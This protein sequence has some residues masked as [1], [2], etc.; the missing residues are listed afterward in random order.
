M[1]TQNIK[2]EVLIITKE[3]GIEKILTEELR[4]VNFGIFE[5]KTYEEIKNEYPNKVE[6]MRNDWRNFK[7]DKGESINEMMLRTAKKMDEI[8]SEH[9][10]K[11]IGIFKDSLDFVNMMGSYAD[12]Q[13][14]V[15]EYIEAQFPIL[16][17][18][19]IF[20]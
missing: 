8:I 18:R 5:G 20:W 9:K 6:E 12:A 11:K 13:Y 3:E 17:K 1:H 4:E 10:D 7:V 14:Y 19:H 2:T 15:N 16:R